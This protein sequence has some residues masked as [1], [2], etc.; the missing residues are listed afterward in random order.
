MLDE[1]LA[2]IEKQIET[3]ML[4][5]PNIMERMFQRARLQKIML[6]RSAGA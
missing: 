5:V 3:K 2:G 1:E 6:K 4:D